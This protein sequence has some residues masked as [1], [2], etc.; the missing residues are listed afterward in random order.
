MS[1]NRSGFVETVEPAPGQGAGR[2]RGALLIHLGTPDAPD[3]AAVR[4]YLCE[5]LSDP[6]VIQLPWWISPITRPMGRLMARLRAPSST[7]MY[8]R[9]WT[10]NGSPL[11]T[12]FDE[13]VAAVRNV[14]PRAWRVYGAMRY[15]S[16]GIAETLRAIERDGIHELIVL[17]MYPQF[18]GTTTGTALREVF[19]YLKGDGHALHVTTRA[20]WHDDHGY[21]TAQAQLLQRYARAAGLRPDNCYLLFSSHG[22]PESYI[23]KGDPYCGQIARTV[24]LVAERLGWPPDRLSLAYQG[25]IGPARWIGPHTD[26]ALRALV[27]R[28]ESRILVCPIGFTT[29]CVETL[30]ELDARYRHIVVGQGGD[31]FLCPA[32]NT[33]GPFIAA[34]KQLI[35][36]GPRPV[37]SEARTVETFDE[38]SHVLREAPVPRRRLVMVGLSVGGRLPDPTIG[39][40]HTTAAGLR[41]VKRSSCAV[42][43]LLRSIRRSAAVSECFLWNTCHRFEL[44]A[45]LA[46]GADPDAAIEAIRMRLLD[47][48]ACHDDEVAVAAG[49]DAWRHLVRTACGLNSGVPGE[50]DILHQLQAAYRLAEKAGT[51]CSWSRQLVE[52]A[53]AIDRTL[54]NTTAWGD[55]DPDYAHIALSRIAEVTGLDYESSRIVVLGGSTTSA[56]VLTTLTD[57]FHVPS[58]QLTLFYRGHKNG[59]HLK[60][61]RHAV[62][63]GRRLRVQTYGESSVG[64]AC[65]DADVIIFGVDRDE[66]VLDACRL[67]RLRDLHARPLTIIDFNTFGSTVDAASVDGVTL[68]SLERLEAEVAVYADELIADP[69]FRRALERAEQFLSTACK[70]RTERAD[71]NGELAA[72][73]PAAAREAGTRSARPVPERSVS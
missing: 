10:D 11:R 57:Q 8:R 14:L 33:F 5:F 63:H 47:G 38:A 54:R 21:V 56:S 3:V 52:E 6:A 30:D 46:D 22:L 44:Y 51:A 68:F 31:M 7:Q 66:P 9:I 16:P 15:G 61:L 62:G 19:D 59:G 17:P 49:D 70:P 1:T 4:R 28:G 20:S 67:R 32:L 64:R 25:Q 72:T 40:V 24:S 43:E 2:R 29:D 27:R 35:L 42:P 48:V 34:L 23:Q 73:L 53:V 65:A 50:R 45:I 69:G 39:D 55:F 26:D 36:R 71:G 12:I 41:S 13:Q 58:R 37:L 60:M 18:S